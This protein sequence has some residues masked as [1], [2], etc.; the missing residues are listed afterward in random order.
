[1]FLFPGVKFEIIKLV[2]PSTR[3]LTKI[4]STGFISICMD[5]FLGVGANSPA[6]STYSTFFTRAGRSGR[7]RIT[8]G[9]LAIL[10]DESYKENFMDTNVVCVKTDNSFNL[11]HIKANEFVAY[12][13]SCYHYIASCY[14]IAIHALRPNDR[15]HRFNAEIIDVE[16]IQERMAVVNRIGL[17][18]LATCSY[19]LD[20]FPTLMKSILKDLSFIAPNLIYMYEYNENPKAAINREIEIYTLKKCLAN[21]S[22]II[23]NYLKT[24]IATK[25]PL[26][27]DKLRSV[28]RYMYNINL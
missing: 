6:V 5:D 8:W 7:E 2:A 23:K 14:S 12:L 24:R 3:L 28:L 15:R 25:E 13:L 21:H 17:R 11:K 4:G 20:W 10:H 18:S 9:R 19:T 1:M 16:Q 22:E 27:Q 26:E